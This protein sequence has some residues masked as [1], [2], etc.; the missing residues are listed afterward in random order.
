MEDSDPRP[1]RVRHAGRHHDGRGGRQG[2]RPRTSCC[3]AFDARARG[4]PHALRRRSSTCAPRSASP[5][6][7][8]PA[9]RP[10]STP[11]YGVALRRAAGRARPRRHR[12]RRG[13][14]PPRPSCPGVTGN[15]SEADMVR[16]M[17]VR[18]GDRARS[19]RSA[20]ATAVKSAVRRAVPPGAARAVRRRAGLQGAQVG[21]ALRARTRAS[22]RSC[23]CRSRRASTAGSTRSR[24]ATRA[25][26]A[27]S[28]YKQIVREKIAIEKRRPDG[29]AADEIRAIATEVGGH[30]RARTARR[31]SPA[32]R[33]RR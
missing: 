22:R 8:T 18:V 31:S 3:E 32:A 25:R 27:D 11:R 13:R 9:C 6:G 2:G 30:A 16:R 4:D 12:A 15:A 17:Q 29:R 28:V 20:A 7:R 23:S 19:A 10:R 26:A 33:P 24:A 5:S 1:D 14:G 21:Q